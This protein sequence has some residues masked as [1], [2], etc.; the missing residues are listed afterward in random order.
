MNYFP[1]TLISYLN[2]FFPELV[3]E[4]FKLSIIFFILYSLIIVLL[5][6]SENNNLYQKQR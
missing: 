2:N 1:I 3:F 5:I 6:T 4:L